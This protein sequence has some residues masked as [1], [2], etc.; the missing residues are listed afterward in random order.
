VSSLNCNFLV[1]KD[2]PNNFEMEAVAAFHN[3][4]IVAFLD[5][6]GKLA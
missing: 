1:C 3:K 4:R 6:S 5:G 2:L